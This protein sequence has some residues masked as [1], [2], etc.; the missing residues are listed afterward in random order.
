MAILGISLGTRTTGIAIVQHKELLDYRTLTVRNT[1]KDTHTATLAHYIQ[2]YR[3]LTVVLKIPPATHLS[4]QLNTILTNILNLF[5]YHGCMVAYKDN[6][7]IKQS[8]PAIRNKHDLIAFAAQH[9]PILTTEQTK[10]QSNK[11]KYH[12]KM[13]EA[14]LIAHLHQQSDMHKNSP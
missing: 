13:F 9:Y 10:E 2:Q 6:T 5:E 4:A 12:H 11:Q 3:I 1:T 7:A 8:V 14:V